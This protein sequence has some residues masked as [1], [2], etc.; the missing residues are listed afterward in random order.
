MK[1]KS[2][3]HAIT[4]GKKVVEDYRR[5]CDQQNKDIEHMQKQGF[6]LSPEKRQEMESK[7]E[8]ERKS[9]LRQLQL[10]KDDYKAYLQSTVLPFSILDDG[11]PASLSN[12]ELRFLE[13]MKAIKPEPKV[14]EEYLR[15]FTKDGSRKTLID[16]LCNVAE[17]QGFRVSGIDR[18]TT[19][20]KADEFS[21]IIDKLN[22]QLK[23]KTW[24]QDNFNSVQSAMLWEQISEAEQKAYVGN[25]KDTL[26]NISVT[27]PEQMP[28]D[29]LGV[30]V[31]KVE[32]P[33]ISAET[34]RAIREG[35][36]P[37]SVQNDFEVEAV[38]RASMARR[39]NEER[40]IEERNKSNP[41]NAETDNAE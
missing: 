3:Y 33:E 19:E 37:G 21:G 39:A 28:V 32:E 12:A 2:L 5:F 6:I 35:L 34:D 13:S 24:F 14:F 27:I 41:A 1:I 8:F 26:D 30:P 38:A 20:E 15:V 29:A 25:V 11:S 22:V 36:N 40:E 23:P 9:A 4:T 10:L 31:E 16:A 17:S 7:Q 18:R